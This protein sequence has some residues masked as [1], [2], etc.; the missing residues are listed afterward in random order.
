MDI[1]SGQSQIYDTGAIEWK[2]WAPDGQHFI[3]SKD[4]PTKIQLGTLGSAPQA[5]TNGIDFQWTSPS[6]F[7]FLSGSQGD[8]T[9]RAG[10]I[11]G[12]FEDLAQSDSRFTEFDFATP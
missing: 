12:S 4:E 6:D 7:L 2:G 5:L 1:P 9:L 11:G 8:W 10:T 3:Y